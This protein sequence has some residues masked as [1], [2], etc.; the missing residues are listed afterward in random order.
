M[1][2]G[3]INVFEPGLIGIIPWNVIVIVLTYI[4]GE[5]GVDI[6][7]GFLEYKNNNPSDK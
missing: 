2:L 7:R 6:V 4:I 1:I 5:S 3:L